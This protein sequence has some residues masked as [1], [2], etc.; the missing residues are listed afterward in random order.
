ML[1]ELL[2]IA[3][4]VLGLLVV[5]GP[6]AI[7]LTHKVVASQEPRPVE[8]AELGSATRAYFEHGAPALV[9]LGF[10]CGA[11]VRLDGMANGVRAAAALW[12]NRS[13]GDTA[14][15]VSS[16]ALIVRTRMIGFE[17]A[18]ED[19]TRVETVNWRSAGCHA[20]V[21]GVH[22]MTLAGVEDVDQIHLVHRARVARLGSPGTRAVAP[23]PG[24]ELATLQQEDVESMERQVRAGRYYFS[25]RHNCYRPTLR[26]ACLM[27]WS[28]T[29]PISTVRSWLAR[30]AAARELAGL[31]L[32]A[33]PVDVRMPTR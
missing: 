6:L 15:I 31:G 19:G 8:L 23:A 11:Y 20:R 16:S 1:W 4:F 27:M 17:T 33:F 5:L 3:P 26:G 32:G 14:T 21:P 2:W 22:K 7:W 18:F 12:V 30:R 13:T 28:L 29:P 25:A 24:E 9:R 10:V